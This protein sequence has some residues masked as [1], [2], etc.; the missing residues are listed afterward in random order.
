MYS[1]QKG[2]P[3]GMLNLWLKK[4]KKKKQLILILLT[5]NAAI[6]ELQC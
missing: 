5:L 4:N 1:N 2:R 3:S 6:Q